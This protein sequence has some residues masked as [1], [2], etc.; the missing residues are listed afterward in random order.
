MTIVHSNSILLTTLQ[1]SSCRSI[2]H[3]THTHSSISKQIYKFHFKNSSQILTFEIQEITQKLKVVFWNIS[4]ISW[5]AV[6]N[7]LISICYYFIVIIVIT[8]VSVQCSWKTAKKIEHKFLKQNYLN[9]KIL[10][11]I[12]LCDK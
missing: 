2:E 6:S 8:I 7:N 1:E 10:F 9:N 3:F 12:N 4:I 11:L 5:D